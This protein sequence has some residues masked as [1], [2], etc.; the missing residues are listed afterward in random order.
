MIKV[1]L[2]L[3]LIGHFLGDFYFQ[4]NKIAQSKE[5]SLSKLIV[6]SLVYFLSMTLGILAIISLSLF[7]WVVLISLLHFLVDWSKSILIRKYP[8]KDKELTSLYLLD[9][10]IHILIIIIVAG[11]IALFQETLQYTGFFKSISDILNLNL[12]L[13]FSSILATIIIIKPVSITIKRV[14]Y[15]YQPEVVKKEEMGHPG[16]G[17]LI[18]ILER[19]IILIM[20]SQNQ[21]AAIGFVLT[22]KSIARYKRII[23]DPK[24]SEYYLLGTLLSMLSVIVTFMISYT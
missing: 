20:L 16:A 13:I 7:K 8:L 1:A 9:Q 23:E 3:L 17:S 2:N 19:L 22:A 21:Y 5:E 11:A 4:T 6:H 15:Q 12:E 10:L 14:L 18:G 24:F